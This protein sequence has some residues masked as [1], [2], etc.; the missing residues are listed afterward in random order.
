[1]AW[2]GEKK[3]VK[4]S[5]RAQPQETECRGGPGDSGFW[6]HLPADL[7]SSACPSEKWG[8]SVVGSEGMSLAGT[9]SVMWPGR[10]PIP[11]H[12]QRGRRRG[13]ALRASGDTE[14][15]NDSRQTVRRFGRFKGD[16][17]LVIKKASVFRMSSSPRTCKSGDLMG[18]LAPRAASCVRASAGTQMLCGVGLRP[19]AG[20]GRRRGTRFTP[21]A[22]CQIP[23]GGK[24]IK[25]DTFS[26]FSKPNIVCL[27][28]P[29]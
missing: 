7:C 20:V 6:P 14:F 1:M 28:G 8:A 25:D 2:H 26:T 12:R 21:E 23:L 3:T 18:S 10:S 22:F 27:F 5:N 15:K 11:S 16:R 17:S 29:N 13:R 24:K 19:P 4:L 9:R